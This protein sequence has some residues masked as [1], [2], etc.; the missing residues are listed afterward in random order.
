MHHTFLP[1]STCIPPPPSPW[2][3]CTV[4]SFPGLSGLT[5][6]PALLP[7]PSGA[8]TTPPHSL[9]LTHKWPMLGLPGCLPPHYGTPC[10][11]Y[12]GLFP[13][14]IW[15][16]DNKQDCLDCCHLS[17]LKWLVQSIFFKQRKC[18][19]MRLCPWI[20]EES[21][22]AQNKPW[23]TYIVPYTLHFW[24]FTCLK[25]SYCKG[26]AQQLFWF[27]LSSQ[28]KRIDSKGRNTTTW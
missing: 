25:H 10:T 2:P 7:Q 17:L 3:P 15:S 28:L 18:K 26:K 4:S 20:K 23:I 27:N 8:C 21:Q 13:P 24:A 14:G 5:Q 6:H 19:M 9:P 11:L 16:Y 1:L 22:G 12:L